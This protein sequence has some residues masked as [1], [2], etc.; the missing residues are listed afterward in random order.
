MLTQTGMRAEND[1]DG[2]IGTHALPQGVDLATRLAAFR[3]YLHRVVELRSAN[4]PHVDHSDV[5]QQTLLDAHQQHLEGAPPTDNGH[6]RHWLR[7]I[8]CCNLA[9]SVRRMT[10][11]KRDVRRE[12]QFGE[13]VGVHSSPPQPDA[14]PA[15]QTSPSQCF[16]RTEAAAMVH[17]ALHRLPDQYRSLIQARFFEGQ[18]I[19][20]IAAE[21]G[22]SESA[23]ASLLFRA[24][25]QLRD[26]LTN[27]GVTP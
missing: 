12:I 24:T 10:R 13:A 4:T 3:G 18:R 9:D 20:E 22:K 19:S 2:A 23:V 16:A 27:L 8:L 11:Q 15:D 17:D 14:I 21:M 1:Q 6:Y 25:R 5:V 26:E 7:R